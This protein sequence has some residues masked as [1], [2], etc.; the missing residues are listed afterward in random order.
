MDGG[1]Y[2]VNLRQKD[3]KIKWKAEL[4][5]DFN[6]QTAKF[7]TDGELLFGTHAKDIRAWDIHT[8]EQKWLK[9]MEHEWGNFVQDEIG[10]LNGRLYVC[11]WDLYCL[12]AN[13]GN[14]LYTKDTPS[15][16]I[17]IYNDRLYSNYFTETYPPDAMV[18][19]HGILSCINPVSGDTLWE[20]ST[21]DGGGR[22]YMPPICED[23]IIYIGSWSHNPSGV[24]AFNAETGEEIWHTQIEGTALF[25]DGVI[26]DDMLVM[27]SGYNHIIGL[28][29]HTGEVQYIK[30][31]SQVM[32]W[33]RLNYYKGYIYTA[34]SGWLH[35]IDPQTGEE[36]FKTHGGDG[37]DIVR[38][39]VGNDRVFCEGFNS[40][41]CLEIYNP[42]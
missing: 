17:T 3:G 29:K 24:Q 16:D 14:I 39:A 4:E 6:I 26:V 21:N 35:V 42:D 32:V 1:Q 10:Y 11:G 33:D 36:V 13:T 27:N 19:R 15:N 2:I 31:I 41:L 22:I 23:G 8:G 25:S 7:V 5:T 18:Q 34:R 28:N 40:L 12:D 37:R 38:I 30:F 9:K 20:R